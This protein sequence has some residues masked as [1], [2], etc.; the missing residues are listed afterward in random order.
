[1]K[2]TT[3]TL[4]KVYNDFLNAK[5]PFVREKGL[6]ILLKITLS[7]NISENDYLFLEKVSDIK[8]GEWQKIVE[9]CKKETIFLEEPSWHISEDVASSTV[10]EHICIA[11]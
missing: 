5:Y 9:V 4:R 11:P 7:Q 6:K 8:K 10:C 1:M 2:N 3:S